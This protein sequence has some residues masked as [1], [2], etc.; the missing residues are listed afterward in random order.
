MNSTPVARRLAAA[1]AV[2]ITACVAL[3]TNALAAVPP[4]S[5]HVKGEYAKLSRTACHKTKSNWRAFHRSST[6]EYRGFLLPPPASHFT[7]RIKIEKCVSGHWRRVHDY[8]VIGENATDKHPGRFKVFYPARPFAPR[9]RHHRPTVA[10][11]RA[12]AL[13]GTT[14]SPEKYFFVTSN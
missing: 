6:I 12:K 11:Y 4:L 10:Y 3:A 1:A 8:Y 2:T 13:V 5:L 7:V 14:I 9:S